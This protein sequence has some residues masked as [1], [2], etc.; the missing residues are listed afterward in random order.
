[1]AFF[2]SPIDCLLLIAE[3]VWLLLHYI[4]IAYFNF[5]RFFLR[6]NQRYLS[7]IGNQLGC[8]EERVRSRDAKAEIFLHW[9]EPTHFIVRSGWF[10]V[11]VPGCVWNTLKWKY[12]WQHCRW[13]L[14]HE[15]L[16]CS[17][18]CKL[19]FAQ[20]FRGPP[21]F[22]WIIMRGEQLLV[23]NKDMHCVHDQ[24]EFC[25]LSQILIST[26]LHLCGMLAPL[27]FAIS[28]CNKLNNKRRLGSRLLK[29]VH[30]AMH[31]SYF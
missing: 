17:G 1:M 31:P 29:L 4:V 25:V 15:T 11:Y 26:I 13:R 9:P 21:R 27:V 5:V 19:M 2:S 10:H 24:N 30:F 16:Q 18:G 7:G 3:I 14:C 28:L 20:T 12:V 8:V 22:C 23:Q 6:E